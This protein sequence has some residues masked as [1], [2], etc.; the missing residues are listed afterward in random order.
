M[1]FG[2][3]YFDSF[4]NFPGANYVIDIPFAY[5]N[6]SNSKLF[7]QTAYNAVGASKVSAL[8]IGNEPNGYVGSKDRPQNWTIE[9]YV[10]QWTNWQG[11]LD[12]TLDL[13]DSKIWE[14]GAIAWA[15]NSLG[16]WAV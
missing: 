11:D 3:S 9:D 5:Q 6:L 14:A 7:A 1:T 16:P 13:N 8:E 12:T 15:N 4:H 2:P 10:S